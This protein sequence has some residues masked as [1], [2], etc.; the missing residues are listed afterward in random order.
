MGERILSI[1][2]NFVKLINIVIKKV[3]LIQDAAS[4]LGDP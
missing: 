3:Y 2:K 1:I 4:F